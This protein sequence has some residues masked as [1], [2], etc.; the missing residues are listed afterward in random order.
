MAKKRD[1][2]GNPPSRRQLKKSGTED[3]INEALKDQREKEAALL[4]ALGDA[5][6]NL[7][8]QRDHLESLLELPPENPDLE[9]PPPDLF[10]AE[11]AEATRQRSAMAGLLDDLE[12]SAEDER[13][14]LENLFGP[15]KPP[16]KK[17]R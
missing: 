12:A 4:G 9:P 1:P 2:Y 5:G 6:S 15:P 7:S 3:W 14:M 17:K 13:A 8:A 11:R 16:K 10:A